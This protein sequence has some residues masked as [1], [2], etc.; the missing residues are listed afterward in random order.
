MTEHTARAFDTDLQEIRRKVG[1]MGGLAERQTAAVVQAL[2]RGDLALARNAIGFDDRVDALQREIEE[3]AIV[4]IARRQPM[5]NDMREIVGAVRIAGDL[6]RI[7]DLAKNI[8]KRVLALAGVPLPKRA[9]RGILHMADLVL[10]QLQ[11]V[12]DSYASRDAEKAVGV[13]QGDGEIDAMNNS[14]FGEVFACMLADPHEIALCT[15]LLFCA[16]NIEREGDHATNI[17]ETVYYI[18]RGRRVGELRP[19][20]DR[21]SQAVLPASAR[22]PAPLLVSSL[23]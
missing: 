7:G 21:T 15:H 16:K 3:I 10:T 11:M 2:V 6:E 8:G 5:A 17:A 4:T 19:K 13:W 1:E 9:A 12:L 22:E 18:I 23:L 14:L 20:G